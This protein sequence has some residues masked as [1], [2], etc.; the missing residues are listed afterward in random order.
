LCR[1]SAIRDDAKP[2]VLRNHGLGIGTHT[3][4]WCAG[5]LL[6]LRHARHAATAMASMLALLLAVGRRGLVGGPEDVNVDVALDC[7]PS[8]AQSTGYLAS[9]SSA[10]SAM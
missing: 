3:P 2:I 5:A 7:S 1:F 6:V 8:S 4:Q 10:V 9:K